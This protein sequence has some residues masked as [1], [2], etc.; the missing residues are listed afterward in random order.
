MVADLRG[1]LHA[2]HGIADRL[3]IMMDALREFTFDAGTPQ[4]SFPRPDPNA[5][6]SMLGELRASM[7]AIEEIGN[8]WVV[9]G[10]RRDELRNSAV[11]AWFL[12]PSGGHGLGDSALRAV[13]QKVAQC[14]PL[15]PN[16][17]SQACLVTVE[18]SPDGLRA[19]RVD[20]AIDDPG[21]FFLGIEVKIDAP[22]Q[23]GQVERYCSVAEARACDGRPWA[24]AFLTP[25]GRMPT[26]AGRARNVIT[27]SWAEIAAALRTAAA[28]KSRN[29]RSGVA[30]HLAKSFVDHINRTL[31]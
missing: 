31:R 23:P 26:T 20:V 14:V 11:L 25:T 30:Y 21:R 19:S 27:I 4:A 15:M 29:G 8:P 2:K 7:S 1:C 18:D 22:E 6:V 9:A 5:L 17:A 12:D 16:S 13:L 3:Q 10:L 24:V 28:G